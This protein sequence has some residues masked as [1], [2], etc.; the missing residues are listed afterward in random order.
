[1]PIVVKTPAGFAELLEARRDVCCTAPR[2]AQEHA[3]YKPEQATCTVRLLKNDACMDLQMSMC[4]EPMLM[5]DV[6]KPINEL[7]Y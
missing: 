4:C 6:N 1:M 7:E 3:T 5:D 2:S